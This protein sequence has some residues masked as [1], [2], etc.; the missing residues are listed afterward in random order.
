MLGPTFAQTINR[1][2]AVIGG[3]CANSSNPTDA[4]RI[5]VDGPGVVPTAPA[6]TSP[7]MVGTPYGQTFAYQRDLSSELAMLTRSIFT[8]QRQLS[9]TMILEVG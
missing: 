3:S 5:G 4:Y 8:I 9:T 6:V 7:F 2:R 1:H